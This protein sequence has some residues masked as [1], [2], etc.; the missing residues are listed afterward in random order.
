SIIRAHT[1][2][3]SYLTATVASLL[4]A[5][6]RHIV[7]PPHVA[8]FGA[9]FH[10]CSSTLLFA[11][12]R[13]KVAAP[14]SLCPH[15]Q[16]PF[17]RAYRLE[18]LR[19]TEPSRDDAWPLLIVAAVTAAI[20]AYDIYYFAYESKPKIP[21]FSQD[22]FHA[23]PLK[24]IIP[25]TS[26][27]SLFRFLA[28]VDKSSEEYKRRPCCNLTVPAPSHVV[29]VDDSCQIARA[30]TPITY[31]PNYFDLLVRRYDNGSVSKTIHDMKVGDYL[32]ARGPFMTWT[33]QHGAY[34]DLVM[35]AGGTGITPMYQLV[36]QLLRHD[37]R[38]AGRADAVRP[39]PGPCAAATGPGTAAAAADGGMLTMMAPRRP[40]RSSTPTYSGGS[41]SVRRGPLSAV[42]QTA[43]AAFSASR[44][45]NLDFM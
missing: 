26:D 40:T 4:P 43:D 35:I 24:D 25:V 28:A 19:K 39:G 8:S 38:L 17:R 9:R 7:Q 11:P 42:P 12:S 30:Y 3:R 14:S 5:A 32:K 22:D 13:F 2:P 45:P 1:S 27:T 31:G 34:D 15:A 33:Y 37:G 41:G 10:A 36:K 20:V 44:R 16:P 29:V 23:F 18:A 6:S 21:P